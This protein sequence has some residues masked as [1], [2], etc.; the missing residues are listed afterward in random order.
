MPGIFTRFKIYFFLN[1]MANGVLM[2]YLG[3]YLYRQG[4]NGVEVAV[5]LGLNPL[6]R[7]LA[8]PIWAVACDLRHIHRK[9]LGLSLVGLAF[10]SV[11]FVVP[12]S[13]PVWV[14]LMVLF[15]ILEAPYIPVGASIALEYLRSRGR[16]SEF[17]SLRLWGSLGFVIANLL[18]GYLLLDSYIQLIPV[19]FSAVLLATSFLV[20][21]LP[22]THQAGS[23][24]WSL[25]I[26]KQ[27]PDFSL[28]LL[29]TVL[30]GF[31]MGVAN[32]YFAVYMDSLRASGALVGVSIALMALPEIPLMA[33]AAGLI[34]RFGLRAALLGGVAVVPLRFLLYA[35][36][37]NPYLVLPVQLLHGVT[38]VS[39]LVVGAIHVSRLL[40]QELSATGQG[41]F[42]MAYGGIGM[43]LGLFIAGL[44]YGAYGLHV[45]W[46]VCAA[47]S[48][49]GYAVIHLSFILAKK[50]RGASAGQPLITENP[51][52][53]TPD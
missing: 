11:L 44:L 9:V 21:T 25:G 42:S 43:A 13:F 12:K 38:V 51:G 28:L 30:V 5:L 40:P 19:M 3:L 36:I 27:Y 50:L 46:L 52:E 53:S 17:G 47:T 31:A 7:T 45:I 18:I 37:Q 48:L 14:L 22:D 10:V 29:G 2:P 15:S 8:Q 4:L 49:A 26:L 35:S 39:L 6:V 32:Q 34:R 1:F 20:W 33:G 23:M 41:L 24:Q 16:H